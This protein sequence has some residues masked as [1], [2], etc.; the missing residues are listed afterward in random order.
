MTDWIEQVKEMYQ[1]QFGLDI[2]EIYYNEETKTTRAY[3]HESCYD[4]SE[5]NIGYQLYKCAC[6]RSAYFDSYI[7]RWLQKVPVHERVRCNCIHCAMEIL[8]QTKFLHKIEAY[9][10]TSYPPTTYNTDICHWLLMKV[11]IQFKPF[12][13]RFSSSKILYQR[14]MFV[15]WRS[16]EFSSS[17]LESLG[18]NETGQQSQKIQTAIVDYHTMLKKFVL[19]CSKK[20]YFRWFLQMK[21]CNDILEYYLKRGDKYRGKCYMNKVTKNYDGCDIHTS[22][23]MFF[24]CLISVIDTNNQDSVFQKFKKNNN[25]LY[26]RL[27]EIYKDYSTGQSG[28][29][30]RATYFGSFAVKHIFESFKCNIK[31][32]NPRCSN[33]YFEWKYGCEYYDDSD[34]QKLVIRANKYHSCVWNKKII[35]KWYLCKGC[36]VYYC[37]K[38]CQKYGWVRFN[39]KEQCQ[40]LQRTF[41]LYLD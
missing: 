29:I 14:F 11:F 33:K 32:G 20:K 1:K 4:L 15:L 8:I 10:R 24:Y 7:S 16:V 19:I 6:S 38:K 37:S 5:S 31:C 25:E 23:D 18:G 30:F 13:Q 12:I 39:H 27:Y 34:N 9:F 35:N 17:H 21:E 41:S 3:V 36:S 22:V 26:K 40:K 2:T 28:K